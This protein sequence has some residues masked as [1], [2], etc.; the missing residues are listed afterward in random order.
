MRPDA[1]PAPPPTDALA[2]FPPTRGG[3][4]RQARR[5]AAL[6]R[7]PL[8]SAQ[9]SP[10]DQRQLR[11]LRSLTPLPCLP[12][13][14]VRAEEP[15]TGGRGPRCRAGP[16]G[17]PGTPALLGRQAARQPAA[18]ASAAGPGRRHAAPAAKRRGF[19]GLAVGR[20]RVGK[21]AP[22]CGHGRVNG[23]LSSRRRLSWLRLPFS[24]WHVPFPPRGNP[25]FPP[26]RRLSL[27]RRNRA[28]RRRRVHSHTHTPPLRAGW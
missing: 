13:H 7:L 26:P 20:G 12:P 25:S 11:R 1:A 6:P 5:A 8:G 18:P 27:P 22:R 16:A 4:G 23:P 15:L 17:H 14:C 21:A 2:T 3:R 9:R 24:P 28:R 10:R 19:P